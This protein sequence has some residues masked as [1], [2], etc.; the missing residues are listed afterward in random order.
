MANDALTTYKEL[1]VILKL[2][3][4]DFLDLIWR[5]ATIL[6]R[7]IVAIKYLLLGLALSIF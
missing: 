2:K 6:S 3:C 1:I 7:E 4:G 5:G